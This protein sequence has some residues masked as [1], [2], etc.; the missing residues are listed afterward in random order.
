MIK[1]NKLA[2]QCLKSALS[3]GVIT[4]NSNP[5]VF[6][7]MISAHW[8]RLWSSSKARCDSNPNYSE[9]EDAAADIIISTMTYLQSI[10]CES[11]EELLRVKIEQQ[12]RK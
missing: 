6:V 7:A 10:G 2:I 8:R 3:R 11:I 12:S 1:L 5:R 9:R 4:G